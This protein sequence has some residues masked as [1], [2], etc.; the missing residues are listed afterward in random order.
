MNKLICGVGIVD[1]RKTR[2]SGDYIFDKAKTLW[3][4]VLSRCYMENLP[5]YKYYKDCT[6]S[7]EW[8]TFSNF[9]QWYRD[10]GESRCVWDLQ[11]DKDLK[12]YGNK[13]YGPDTCMLISR[14]LNLLIRPPSYNMSLKACRD[15]GEH[16][17]VVAGRYK[18]LDLHPDD[19]LIPDYL[20]VHAHQMLANLPT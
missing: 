6:V 8:L 5:S 11:L 16:L 19:K 2:H 3:L 4:G 14:N 1:V 17:L 10:K 18:K 7:D 15:K 12:V 9:L 20:L 13:V